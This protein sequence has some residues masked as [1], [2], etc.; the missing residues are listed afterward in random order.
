MLWE[1]HVFV[2]KQVGQDQKIVQPSI[3]SL[4]GFSTEPHTKHSNIQYQFLTLLPSARPSH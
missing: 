1:M 2:I 4:S 3:M